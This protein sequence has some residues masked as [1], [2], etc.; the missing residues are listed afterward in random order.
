MKTKQLIPTIL[1]GF[2]LNVLAQN[3]P[4]GPPPDPVA[5]ALDKNGNH[6]LSKR[7]IRIA[8]RSL[9]KLDE[10]RDG[11]LSKEELRPEPPEGRRRKKKDNGNNANP[12]PA[13]PPSELLSAID[14]N[15]DGSLSK[16]ELKAAPESLLKMDRDDD[17]KLNHDEAP[18]LGD[19]NGD[20]AGP[21]GGGGGGRP[22][23]PPGRGGGPPRR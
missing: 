17:G 4:P 3:M 1:I 10:D 19:P 20:R 12:P 5:M 23:H 13:P 16:E 18:S 15:G 22:P 9:G 2:S 14:T 6:E 8:A 11:V 21:P 7:E